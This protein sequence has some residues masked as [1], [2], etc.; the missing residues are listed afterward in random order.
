H[1]SDGKS[2]HVV[3]LDPGVEDLVNA[4]LERTDRGTYLA[5]PPQAANRLVASIRNE[6]EAAA[7]RS[8]GQQ[9][10]LLAS[11]QVRPFVRRLIESA[12]P[13]VAVLAYNEI[14]HGV[15]VKAHGIVVWN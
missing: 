2:L 5:L 14:V 15:E 10:V 13:A 8:G 11:P 7:A 4:H 12:L 3:T 1:R 6:V 9:P